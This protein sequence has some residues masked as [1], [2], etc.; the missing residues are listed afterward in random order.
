MPLRG[1]TGATGAPGTNGTNGVDGVD[2]TDPGVWMTWSETTTDADPGSGVMRADNADLSAATMLFVSKAN[3]AGDDVSAWLAHL[4]DSTNPT[5]KGT[6]TISRT[7]GNA[8]ATFDLTALTDATGYVKLAV[9]N[10]SGAT[11]FFTNDLVSMQFSAA[12]DQ[13]QSGDGT[14]DVIGPDG[15]NNNAIAVFDGTTG[16]L[17]KDGGALISDFPTKANNLSDLASLQVAFDNLSLK[18]ANKAS[19]ATLD[20]DTATGS[21]VDVTGTTTTTAITLSEGRQRV[22]RATGAWPITVGANLILNNGGAN[23]TCAAG[24]MI[25][26]RGYGS[27]VVRGVIFPISGRAPQPP[28]NFTGDSGTGGVKG[29]VPAPAAGDA[30]ASKFLSADGSWR[31]VISGRER[32]TANRTYYVRSDGS[33][34]NNGLADTS[35]GA[36][37]TIQKAVDV[38]AALDIS[39]FD[40]TIQVGN[41]TY[42]GVLLKR[43]VGSGNV[44]IIGNV[45]NPALCEVREA[46]GGV[47]RGADPGV[48]WTIKGF[49]TST[50][51]T[52]G[53]GIDMRNGARCQF[54]NWNF[55]SQGTGY[56]IYA[57]N[58]GFIGT[59]GTTTYAISGGASSHIRV[60]NQASVA[61]TGSTVVTLSGTPGFSPFV[62]VQRGSVLIIFSVTFSGSSTGTR[63]SVAS[64]GVIETNGGGATYLPG[65]ANG[66]ATTGGQYL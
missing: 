21:L 6:L 10:G 36:F 56:H 66:T 51:G 25:L 4:V 23:Y 62:N 65:S 63:Y 5:R 61:I 32:L 46:S 22:V 19:A 9:S 55:G 44:S 29:L 12:G 38:V 30:A 48:N 27:G 17:V 7:G 33:D 26:F 16:K 28:A 8:Q 42:A 35:G 49:K 24:D 64:N 39:I 43:V 45:T 50:T 15:A 18:G 2:G 47:F 52:G 54:A 57:A 41:G 14:G 40:A 60:E 11:G 3:R 1:A 34:S 31:E 58:G 53:Q 59:D 37:L 13:G 20:L